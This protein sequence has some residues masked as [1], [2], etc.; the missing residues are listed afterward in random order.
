[1]RSSNASPVERPHHLQPTTSLSLDQI[2]GM[3]GYRNASALRKPMK[4]LQR[5]GFP[6][7]ESLD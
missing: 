6:A 5:D 3:V 1:M 4:V 7:K 2:A